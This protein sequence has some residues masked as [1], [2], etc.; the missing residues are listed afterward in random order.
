MALWK[1]LQQSSPILALAE[2][3]S[4]GLVSIQ[5]IDNIDTYFMPF[6]RYICLNII[7]NM[8]LG[9]SQF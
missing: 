6:N 9:S 8:Y 3:Q 1:F 5:N 4:T 2:M 7:L